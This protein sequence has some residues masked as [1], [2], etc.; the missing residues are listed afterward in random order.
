[1]YPKWRKNI[2][3]IQKLL[4]LKAIPSFVRKTAKCRF[5]EQIKIETKQ[6]VRADN[7]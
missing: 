2:T 1:M 3:I 7:L 5:P 4:Y 6:I